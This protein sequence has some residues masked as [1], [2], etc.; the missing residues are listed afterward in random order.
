MLTAR[1]GLR[2]H[3]IETAAGRYDFSPALLIL[4]AAQ[5]HGIQII[6]DVLHFG[7][8]S[9]LN[10]FG[11]AWIDSFG[12]FAAAF[13]RL[14][15]KEMSEPAF[16]APVNEISFLSWAGGDTAYVNPFA[17]GRGHELKRQLVGG[18][19]QAS[20]ALRSELNNVHLVSPEPVIHIVGDPASPDD[21]VSAEQY[22]C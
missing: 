2:W 15:A 8:P 3:L 21:M 22:R 13:G 16:V 9:G 11:P 6:W 20:R 12:A 14:L 5:R 7:W 1:E 17:C 19:I 4:E 10:I 18:A